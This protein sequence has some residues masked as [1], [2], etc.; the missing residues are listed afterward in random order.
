MLSQLKWGSTKDKYFAV[1]NYLPFTFV[2]DDFVH[3]L[4]YFLYR[5]MGV[6]ISVKLYEYYNYK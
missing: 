4:F 5:N 1:L 2:E 3:F 6:A